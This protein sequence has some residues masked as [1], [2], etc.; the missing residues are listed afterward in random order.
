MGVIH[1]DI[2]SANLLFVDDVIKICDLNSCK[3]VPES[4]IM[5]EIGT[6]L[7]ASPEMWSG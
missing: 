4:S 2:K 3:I 1:R 5:T 7:Y 6:P